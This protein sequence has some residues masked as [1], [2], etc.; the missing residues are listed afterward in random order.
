MRA[1]QGG[2]TQYIEVL[3][4]DGKRDVR[5]MRNVWKKADLKNS[6][7]RVGIEL[8]WLSWA[9]ES[10]NLRSSSAALPYTALND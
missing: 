4:K 5:W 2:A 6:G 3:C 8:G 7:R 9:P 10:E 1:Q